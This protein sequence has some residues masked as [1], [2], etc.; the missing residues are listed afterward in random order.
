MIPIF[1]WLLP[2]LLT[3]CARA[4]WRELCNR[5]TYIAKS[6]V[7]VCLSTKLSLSA[8][9][10]SAMLHQGM[11]LTNS[12]PHSFCYLVSF[13]FFIKF[14]VHFYLMELLFIY[15]YLVEM[16][17]HFH[18]VQAPAVQFRCVAVATAAAATRCR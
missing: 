9:F 17:V 2:L 4:T 14:C 7:C 11:L 5:S 13:F 15:F 8:S 18:S 10:N 1:I 6:F 16:C 3:S 12:N